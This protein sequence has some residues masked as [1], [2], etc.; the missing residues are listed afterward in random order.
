MEK[1]VD[2]TLGFACN[3]NC[4]FCVV[5][6]KK[7]VI[8]DFSTREAKNALQRGI[9]DGAGGVILTGGEPTVR[10]DILELVSYARSLGFD[11]IIIQSN[12]RMF[13][14]MDFCIRCVRNGVTIYAFSLH[15]HKPE[16]HDHLTRAPGS[17]KQTTTGI[18]NLKSLNQRVVTNTVITKQNYKT[19]PVTAKL[20]INLGV[21]QIKF[22]FPHIMGNAL[23]NL[24]DV[25]PTKTEVMPYVL[26]GL[27]RGFRA[28]IPV[29]IEAIPFCFLKGYERC[30]LDI[31]TPPV[32]IIGRHTIIPDFDRIRK[33]KSKSKGPRCK[34][35]KYYLVCEGPWREY[36][37][38]FGW[39]EFKP[40]PGKK[41]KNIEEIIRMQ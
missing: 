13:Y 40:V 39:D 9:D 29:L 16:I 32:E 15:G 19:I 2:V 36:P 1:K 24:E 17:F 30:C 18:K 8:K 7:D 41:V 11:D 38:I 20:L 4:R 12:G 14:Y 34:E 35:C 25:I 23:K 6:D 27:K 37:E 31:Y 22:S 3:N 26:K 21:D 10:K 33:L 28:N 5:A